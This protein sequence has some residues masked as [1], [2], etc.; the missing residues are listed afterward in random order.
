VQTHRA[1]EVFLVPTMIQRLLDHP[2]FAEFDLT[3]LKLMLYGAAPI[4]AALLER[5]MAALPNADFAQAYGMTELAPTVVV[6]PAEAHRPAPNRDKWLRAAGRPVPIAEIRI[7]DA[8][9]RECPVG[10]VGEIVARGP[11][12]MQ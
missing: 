7:V 1:N 10:T 12:V 6:L 2:R 8:E 9:G 4:D 5:A 3:S 11:T